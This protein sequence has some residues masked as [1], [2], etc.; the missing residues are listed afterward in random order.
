[1][2]TDNLFIDI[3]H[4]WDASCCQVIYNLLENGHHIG[5]SIDPITEYYNENEWFDSMVKKNMIELSG[6]LINMRGYNNS[7]KYFIEDVNIMSTD[8][9][10][11]VKFLKN[12]YAILITNKLFRLCKYFSDYTTDVKLHEYFYKH[13]KIAY[14]IVIFIM[15][16]DLL[17]QLVV[18][19]DIVDEHF[20]NAI[21][22]YLKI[23]TY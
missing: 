22:D 7:I 11:S 8:S 16:N 23:D 18:C 19:D 9:N 12:N 20:F 17:K 10:Y 21:T 14:P 13:F 1:M 2:E 4:N 15:N 3:I 5:L 6:L